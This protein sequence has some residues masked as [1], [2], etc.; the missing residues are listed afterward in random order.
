MRKLQIAMVTFVIAAAG[1]AY[2]GVPGAPTQLF[3]GGQRAVQIPVKILANVPYAEVKI[4]GRGPF[5]FLVD[6][7]SMNSPFARELTEQMGLDRP[8]SPKTG[9][10]TEVGLA[11]GVSVQIPSSFASFAGLSALPGRTIYGDVGYNVLKGF[12]VEIDYEHGVITL[13]DPAKFRYSGTAVPIP[14]ELVMG[15]DP[16][17]EGELS[18]DDGPP[19]QA[20]FTL[21]TGA[22]GTVVSVPLVK[23]N[24]MLRRVKQQVPLPSSKALVDGVNGLVYEAITGRIKSVTF[25]KYTLKRPLVALSRDTDTVFAEGMLG[26]NLGGNVLRRFNVFIDYPRQRLILEP[27]GHFDEPF[28]ADASGLV[29]T[30][31]GA[32]YKTIVVH[33]VVTGSP[34]DE[35]GMKDGDVITA[36]DG[37]STDG[38]ALYEIQ[39]LFKESGRQRQVTIKRGD[40]VST[41]TLKLRALA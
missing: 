7:G 37:K 26:V 12:V 20:K 40:K 6:T 18:V 9:Q 8:P 3:P 29:L 5:G 30:T 39:E 32:N 25:G 22:G 38:Y 35:G 34:A 4:N 13:F 31:E 19:I 36:I 24:D 1:T 23:T 11:E 21:D 41:V 15:Y 17:F 10:P 16:Q 28:A 33:G 27:N 2:T 14:F